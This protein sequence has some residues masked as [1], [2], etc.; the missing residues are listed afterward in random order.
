MMIGVSQAHLVINKIV[1]NNGF[2]E[3]NRGKVEIV[4]HYDIIIHDI[5]IQEIET[6]INQL[7]TN[8]IS[9]NLD[10][11]K[12]SILELEIRRIKTK[13]HTIVPHRQRRGLINFVGTIHKWLY[14][15]MDNEDR[16]N[17]EKHLDII[18]AN[19]HN[20][21]QNLNQQVK[22]NNNFNESFER[23]KD[24]LEK[25]RTK[26]LDSYNSI[27]SQ[28]KNLASHTF[29]I[30]YLLKIKILH[31]NLE[32]IQDNVAS[33]RT[34]IIH[35]NLLTPQEIE[36]YDI[37]INKL[38]NIKIGTLYSKTNHLTFV[39]L[40][41]R[42]T[43]QVDKI[44]IFPMTNDNLE[45]LLFEPEEIIKYNN[46]TYNFVSNKELSK[47]KLS[48]N[49]IIKN[50]CMKIWNNATDILE[51]E[52]GI[53]LVKNSRNLSLANNC[54]QKTV[55]LDGNYL[56][57]FRNCTI[58]LDNHILY[59]NEKEFKQTF[60]IPQLEVNIKELEKKLTFDEL[61]FKQVQNT[62]EIIELRY[63]KT[64]NVVMN[65]IVTI[66]IIVVLIIVIISAKRK[67]LKVKLKF[68]RTQESP[69][70][71]DGGVTS[72]FP[73]SNMPPKCRVAL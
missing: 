29:Y 44:M 71:K 23:L 70:S 16:D 41:P 18:D 19:N 4:K 38:M 63:H 51:I 66:I 56:I 10:A 69:Q 20:I 55:T 54:K 47:L 39:I 14:G 5:N 24:I 42:E 61:I 1:T 32:H 49:C 43:I 6:I 26:I 36:E 37:N 72:E 58:E 28:Y 15:T 7:R 60:V 25:D 11:D 33:S 27:S 22:I 73:A 59:N 2:I 64:T 9:L 12:T 68:T 8:I 45:E 65:C 57:H 13:L 40:V 53:V 52:T 46:K 50:N 34:G 17:I 67:Q 62:K 21:I 30:D 48:N 3:I 35:S 31:D